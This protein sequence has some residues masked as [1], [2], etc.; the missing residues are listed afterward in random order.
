MSGQVIVM[1]GLPGSGKT[2]HWK[3]FYPTASAVSSDDFFMEYGEYNFTLSFH[4]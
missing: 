1:R 4:V 2:T 3:K